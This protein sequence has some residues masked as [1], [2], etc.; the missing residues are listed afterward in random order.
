MQNNDLLGIFSDPHYNERVTNAGDTMVSFSAERHNVV[1]GP[2]KQSRRVEVFVSKA[3]SK[4]D[5]RDSMKTSFT[6]AY[7]C[8]RRAC[9]RRHVE[10]KHV[11]SAFFGRYIGCAVAVMVFVVHVFSC[12]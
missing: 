4:D 8:E 1:E 11:V 6:R 10:G 12:P 7:T 3:Q 5:V 9:E 2:L